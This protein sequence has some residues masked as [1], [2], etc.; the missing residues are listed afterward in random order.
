MLRPRTYGVAQPLCTVLLTCAIACA[1]GGDD[2]HYEPQG[3]G[4]PEPAIVWDPEHYVAYIAGMDLRIDGRLDEAA[5]SR[6]EWTSDFVD[7][8]G[9]SRPIP[10]FRT[11]AKMLWDSAYFYIGAELS[12]PHV[13]GTLTERDAVI[14]YDNDFEVFIDP[15]G[16]T[17]EYYEL[18]INALGTEWDL[19]LVK[20]YRDGGPALNAWDI[21]GLRTAVS[22]DGTLNDPSDKDTAWFVEIAIPWSVLAEA[23]RR[24]APP[25]GGDQWRVNFSRV[26]WRAEVRDGRYSKIEEPP[27]GRS[28]PEDNWVWSPQGLI[29]MHYPEM[30]GFVQFSDVVV[31]EGDEEFLP[32]VED[33]AR[34][35]LRQAY[36]K[37]HAWHAS[38]GEFSNDLRSLGL[39][40]QVFDLNVTASRRFFDVWLTVEEREMHIG[41]DGRIW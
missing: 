11:R 15:D 25:E 18:E 14:Y 31:G 22:I 20:P 2:A 40:N 10:R 34:W 8:E 28:R 24:S 6:A 13:W 41:A 29:N 17:H 1:P 5:W 30:W 38:H 26:Q 27:E 7:I 23:A 21:N 32:R 19:F 33:Q 12:E 39:E 37:Q 35:L 9:P 16:D 4:I 36:Y 3:D